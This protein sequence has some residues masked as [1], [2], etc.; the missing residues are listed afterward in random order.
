MQMILYIPIYIPTCNKLMFIILFMP[1][2][3]L[4]NVCVPKTIFFQKDDYLLQENV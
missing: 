3:S 1:H 4:A 2:S